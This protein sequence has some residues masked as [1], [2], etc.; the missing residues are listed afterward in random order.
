MVDF[1]IMAQ[2]N[3]RE[4]NDIS[5]LRAEYQLLADK[6][7]N[8]RVLHDFAVG[9][10]QK[11]T[12]DDI[13]WSIAKHAIAKLGFVD[14]VVYLVDK[15]EK[16]LVQK[17]A[18]GPKNP[19]QLDILNPITIPLGKGIVGTVAV[20]KE[21][22]LIGDTSL[23][24][25]YIL[26]DDFRYS[27]LAVPI[28]SDDQVI[29][30]IDSEHPEKNFF[31]DQH[32]QL[33]Q[34][35][36]AMA[37]TKILHAQAIEKLQYYQKDL[38]REVAEKTQT[39]ERHVSQLKK[40]NDDLES[41][42]YATSH[43]LA[44]PLRTITSFLQLLQKKEPH[45]KPESH[46]YINFAVTAAHRMRNLLD[47]LLIYSRVGKRKDGFQY[48]DTNHILYTVKS[49]LSNLINESDA[50]IE[51]ERL[52]NVYGREVSI[53]QLF[54]NL[55]VNAIKFQAPN[56]KPHIVIK[57]LHQGDHLLFQIIDNGIGIPA[58]YHE[59]AFKLFGRLH[60]TRQ[61][62]GSGLGLAICKSVVENHNGKIWLESTMEGGTTVFF[63][64]QKSP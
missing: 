45:L 2:I 16:V 30:V 62:K 61:Y 63:T 5:R 56:R 22:E 24:Q 8:L 12:I 31:T 59:K 25:R 37:S 29:G 4:I 11:H 57:A 3:I 20:T 1:R 35:I 39:L 47:G 34:T 32:L 49:S 23:D 13:V 52:P 33:L 48:L 7:S 54:Q 18:H 14:C 17:A 51:H 15:A 28:L 27:E 21:P 55:I 50:I 36:A 64:I 9:L 6:E 10:I 53:L 38:E 58:K 44:E 43:D 19:Q 46:D 42:A 41:F 26:D 60:T 40:S